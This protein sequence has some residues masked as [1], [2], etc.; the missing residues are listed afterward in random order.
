MLAGTWAGNETAGAGL[1]YSMALSNSHD[2]SHMTVMQSDDGGASFKKGARVY[3]G[4]AAYQLVSWSRSP[5]PLARSSSGRRTRNWALRTS[6]TAVTG[7]NVSAKAARSGGQRC[8]P[9]S[10]PSRPRRHRRRLAAAMVCC[11]VLRAK[12]HRLCR[13]CV[14]QANRTTFARC[15]YQLRKESSSLS[16]SLSHDSISSSPIFR[17]SAEDTTELAQRKTE[18]VDQNRT[19][20]GSRRPGLH[21][22]PPRAR[23]LDHLGCREDPV[24]AVSQTKTVQ[25]W[26]KLW[27]NCGL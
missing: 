12:V 13:L 2:R 23:V 24:A 11:D 7:R 4:P 22:S 10:P 27:P 19:C 25:G 15:S 1:F 18:A 16:N 5:P 20:W 21:H 8:Q 26:P 9:T 14:C 17:L 6:G 3:E